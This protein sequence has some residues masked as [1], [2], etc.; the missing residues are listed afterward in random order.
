MS[1]NAELVPNKILVGERLYAEAINIILAN[2]KN[3]LLIFDQDLSRGDFASLEKYELLRNFLNANI[4]SRLTI[5]LQDTAYFRD[6]CP[7]LFN[8]LALY[9]HKMTVYETNDTAKHAKDCFILADG[10]HYIKRIHID[11]ARF[12]YALNDLESVEQLNSRFEEL[13]EATQDVVAVTQTGL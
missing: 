8:L 7:R 1:D 12:K 4:N 9:G 10:L 6:H 2:A 3:E 11:Q 13:L 5:V